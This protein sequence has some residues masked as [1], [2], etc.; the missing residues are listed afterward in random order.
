MVA[1]SAVSLTSE[2]KLLPSGGKAVRAAWG[3]IARRSVWARVMPILAAA[4]HWPRSIEL[5]AARRISQA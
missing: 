4:S 2:M 5:I 1:A 3:K